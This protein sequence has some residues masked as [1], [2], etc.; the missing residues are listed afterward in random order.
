MKI[1]LQKPARK[2]LIPIA[3]AAALALSASLFAINLTT[4][5]KAKFVL[6]AARDLAEGQR[7][8]PGDF[9]RISLP[10]GDLA[11]NYLGELPKETVLTHSISKGELIAKLSLARVTDVRV[12]IR[13]NNLSPISKAISVGDFVDVWAT[14]LSPNSTSAPEPIAFKALV[15]AIEVNNSMTQSSTSVEL[16]IDETYLE[17]VLSTTDSKY[18]LALILH[19]TLADEQ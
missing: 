13:L 14:E 10:I 16:R 15:T 9:Q 7:L 19:E 18:R 3:S 5:P 6:V 8:E 11:R 1:K 4:T 2:A 12:P 17:S